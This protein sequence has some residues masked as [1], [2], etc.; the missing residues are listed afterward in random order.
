[1]SFRACL[2][3]APAGIPE[4]QKKAARPPHPGRAAFAQRR[5]YSVWQTL[6][7]FIALSASVRL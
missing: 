5:R 6:T 2:R 1:M 4:E 3:A 7:V